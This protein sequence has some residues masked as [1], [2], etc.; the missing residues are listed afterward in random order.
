MSPDGS[1]IA[2]VATDGGRNRLWVRPLSALTA[3]SLP[4]TE[5]ARMPFWSPDSQALGFFAAGKLLRIQATGGVPQLICEVP[6]ATTPD[7]GRDGTILFAQAPD[8]RRRGSG[9][10]YRVPA[11]G[12][13]PTQLT[14][15]Q[16]ASGESEHYW[17]SFLP[18]AV[19]FLYVVT[20]AEGPNQGRRHS[21]VVGSIHMP[22]ISSDVVSLSPTSDPS[23]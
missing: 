16:E 23:K 7:W 13:T 18:D 9:G 1:Q 11:N 19:H 4:G 12:G 6:V 3:S 17:P 5:D 2:F 14:L 10:V 8:A 15:V 20:T 21:L 22:F